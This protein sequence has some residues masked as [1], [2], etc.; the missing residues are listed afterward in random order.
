MTSKYLFLLPVFFFFTVICKAQIPDS[1]LQDINSL[2]K[3][4]ETLDHRLDELEKVIDDVLWYHKVGDVAFIDKVRLTG[5]PLWKEKNPTGQGAGNPVKFYAYVFVPK[6]IDLNKKY[7]LIVFPH[8]G[9]HS[10]FSTY[11]THIVKELMAQQYIVIAAEYRGSTG[12]GKEFRYANVKDWGY[13]DYEDVVSGVDKVIEMGIGDPDNQYVMGWSYGG[14]LTSFTVTRTDRFNA[15]SMG[16]GL[17]NLISMTTTTDIQDYLVAH[18]G[19]K[20]YWDDYKTYE[21]HSAIYRI[22]NVVTPTQILHGKNDQRVPTSQGIEFYYSL[23][24]L[25]VDSEMILYPRTQHGPREPKFI[26]DIGQKIMLW[27]DKYKTKK[28]PGNN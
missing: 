14:Y 23:K 22:K 2:K 28:L 8:G 6:N 3:Y 18:M 27:F 17:P 16:A 24:R 25:G 15:A 26:Q 1:V 10:N 19:G 11:Y 12:Y 13:G 9:V 7:P 20:E 4:N 21:K 5:P